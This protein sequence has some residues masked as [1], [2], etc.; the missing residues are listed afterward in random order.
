MLDRVHDEA[1][2]A[3]RIDRDGPPDPPPPDIDAVWARGVP[4]AVHRGE[5]RLQD[6]L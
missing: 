2:Y 4:A 1:G 6:P 5:P 3:Y